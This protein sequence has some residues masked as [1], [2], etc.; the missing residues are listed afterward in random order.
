MGK[1]RGRG[2]AVVVEEK[3]GCRIVHVESFTTAIECR[4]DGH[5]RFPNS[6]IGR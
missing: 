3:E 4:N 6:D 2:G 5:H 1:G